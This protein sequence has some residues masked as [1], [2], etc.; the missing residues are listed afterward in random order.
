[1]APELQFA[2]LCP[3]E[4]KIRGFCS[5]SLVLLQ[6]VALTSVSSAPVLILLMLSLRSRRKKTYQCD[7]EENVQNIV[8]Y[9]NEGGGKQDI[10]AFDITAMWNLGKMRQDMQDIESLSYYVPQDCVHCG[11]SKKDSS[12]AESLSW[13]SAAL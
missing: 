9:N 7:G 8:P 4:S 6:F 10:K 12:V 13:N 1:M 5:C 2:H 3:K 11:C